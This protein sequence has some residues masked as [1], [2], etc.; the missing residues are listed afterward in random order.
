M[1]NDDH[2]PGSEKTHGE[3]LSKLSEASLRIS[4][5]LDPDTVLRE[6]VQSARSLTGAGTG[7]IVTMNDT[8]EFQDFVTSGVTNEEY[9]RMLNLPHGIE[10]W[11]YM[12]QVS[13]PLRVKNLAT[14]FS[15]L[16]FPQ[17]PSMEKSCL[18]VQIRHQGNQVGTFV[19]GDKEGSEGFSIEDAEILT[20]FASHAGAA[21]ANSRKHLDEKRARTDLEVLIDTSPVGVVVIDA[22]GRRVASMNQESRRILGD[23][24]MPGQSAEDLLSVIK[25]V[26][27]NG[28]EI[29]LEDTH[30]DHALRDAVSVRAEE[31][32]LEVPDGRKVTTVINAT[33]IQSSAG[34]VESLVVTMQDMTPLEAQERLRAEFL[35]MVSHE[36]RAPLTSVKGCT[37]TILDA[38]SVALS[39]EVLRFMQII[40]E[41]AD[42]MLKLIEDLLDAAHIETGTLSINPEPTELADIVDRARGMYYSGGGVNPINIDLPIGLLNVQADRQRIVQVLVNL[43]ANAARHSAS[44]SPIFVTAAQADVHVVV[45]VSDDGRGIPDEQLPYLFQKFGGLGRER[46]EIGAGAGLGLSIC[47]GLVEAHG[48]RIWVENNEAGSGSRF[49]FTIPMVEQIPAD[50]SSDHTRRPGKSKDARKL[51]TRI[52]VVDDDPQFLVNIR[53][54]LEEGGYMPVV[55]ADPGEVP[56]LIEKN[57]PSLVLLDLLLPGKDGIELMQ[58]VPGLADRPVI[59]VS[60][61]GRDETIASALDAGAVDYIVKPFSQAELLARINV[62][63]RGRD[64]PSEPFRVGDLEINYAERLVTLAGRNLQLTATEYDVLRVLSLK[65][66][67]VT[68]YDE[69]LQLVWGSSSSRD[70]SVIRAIVMKLRRKL[71]DDASNPK[72]IRTESRVGLRMPR[73][74]PR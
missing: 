28:G 68:T 29:K 67:R 14:H 38:P 74:L 55:T 25:V 5:S 60:A 64:E 58:S 23:L 17:E 30:I 45:S 35:G 48:G 12:R 42:H 13:K 11:E 61:F 26:R 19:L 18:I 44:S 70:V 9:Q 59:F 71:G 63:L 21:I 46:H 73:L 47:K 41:Q 53:R 69:M 6:I 4:E 27:A 57:S 56:D 52:L 1:S 20:L 24:T 15:S 10:I 37:A 62:A 8:G 36:L 33:P 3:Q 65:V 51:K 16:G 34:E 43:L 39:D 7:G 66:G 50:V 54:M 2:Y 22:K 49:S 72:Y 32:V 31:I 40:D